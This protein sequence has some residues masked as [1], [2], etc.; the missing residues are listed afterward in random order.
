M[1][2]RDFQTATREAVNYFTRHGYTSERALDQWTARLTAAAQGALLSPAEANAQIA[3]HL[4]AIYSRAMRRLPKHLRELQSRVGHRMGPELFYRRLSSLPELGV[5]MR[6]EFERRIAASADLVKLGR[7]EATATAIRRFRGWASSIPAGGTPAVA[8]Q[9]VEPIVKEFRKLRFEPVKVDQG[10]K[11]TQAL[12][13]TVAEGTGAIAAVWHSNWRQL[14]Y[15]FR[16]EHKERDLQVYTVRDNWA[17][18]RGLM[19]PGPA[20]YT[21]EITQPAEEPRCRC[22]YQYV[23]NLDRLPD[24]MLTERG[25]RTLAALDQAGAERGAA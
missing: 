23:Y 19:K 15:N 10:R 2:L 20:G 12:S 7:E 5:K 11:L 14:H 24:E 3:R 13:S 6:N 4:S 21:D 22:W 1:S 16:P 9:A 18:L 8:K 17:E 25:K